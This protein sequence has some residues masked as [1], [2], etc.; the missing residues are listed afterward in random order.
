[1][2]HNVLSVHLVITVPGAQPLNP[3]QRP[4]HATLELIT[5]TQDEDI[6]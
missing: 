1:M 6:N 5:Q 2:A 3:A 4:Y